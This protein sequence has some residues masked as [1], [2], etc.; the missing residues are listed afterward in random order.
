M[1]NKFLPVIF[2]LAALIVSCRKEKRDTLGSSISSDN[3]TAENLFSEMFKVVDEVSSNTA[4]IRE[5]LCIDTIIVDTTSIPKTIL[6]DFGNDECTSNDG[7]IRKGKLNVTY[8]GRYREVGTVITVTPENYTVNGNLVQGQK[9]ITNLGLN[10]NGQLHFAIV[11]NG[12]VTAPGNT[13][14]ISWTANRTRTWV[15]GQSTATLWDDIYEI[16]GSGSGVNR[17]GVSYTST[18]TQALRAKLNCMWIVSGSITLQPQDYETRYID[19]G[20]GTCDSGFTVTVDGETYQLGS[21]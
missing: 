1:K 19:F 6:I 9:T 20:N 5:D 8:T 10:T 13:W 7:R 11:V 18:I 4:G 12:S 16:T 15:E 14:T 17:N 2:A 21:D 3:S